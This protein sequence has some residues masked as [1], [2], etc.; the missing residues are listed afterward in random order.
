MGLTG[1]RLVA[2]ANIHNFRDLGG[3]PGLD[4]ATVRWRRLYRADDLSRVTGADQERVL[5]PRR[6]D[7]GRPAP[8]GRD[9]EHRAHPGL[10]RVHLPPHPPRLPVVAGDAV[11]RHRGA[12]RLRDRALPGDGRDRHRR[13]GRRVAA[14]RR[15]RPRPAGVPLHRRQGPHRRGGGA[16]AQPARRLRRGHRRRLPPVSERAEAANWAW[17]RSRDSNLVDRRW[18]NITV[19]PPQGMLDFLVELRRATARSRPTP[20]RSA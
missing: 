13:D 18:Q 3:Y 2:F 8:A 14:D 16:D 10:R 4:G 6:A 11:R 17:Y 20:P 9:R 19:S 7:R 1:E 12:Q 5:R 15:R